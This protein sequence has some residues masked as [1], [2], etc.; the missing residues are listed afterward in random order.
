[1]SGIAGKNELVMIAL[2]SQHSGH[3]LIRDAD[4]PVLQQ[5][6]FIPNE[7]NSTGQQI[8]GSRRLMTNTPSKK[9]LP[10][11]KLPILSNALNGE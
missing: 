1:M 2:G 11:R 6:E 10:N 5:L 4:L 3:V 9:F 7:L 8:F